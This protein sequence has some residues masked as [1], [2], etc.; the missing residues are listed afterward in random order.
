LEGEDFL[1]EEDSA[2]VVAAGGL[3]GVDPLEVAVQ[4][5]AGK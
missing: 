4:V 1:A 2:A 5:E 3:E